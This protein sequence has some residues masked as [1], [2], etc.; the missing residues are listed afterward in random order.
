MNV[1]QGF[2]NQP[3]VSGDEHGS[4][5]NVNF[6]PSKVRLSVQRLS[7]YIHFIS[8]ILTLLQIVGNTE[9]RLFLLGI[10][11]LWYPKERT[12]GP[13][14]VFNITDIEKCFITPSDFLELSIRVVWYPKLLIFSQRRS[15]LSKARE[16]QKQEIM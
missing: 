10:W 6:N 3:A 11:S 13:L 4:A 12:N 8:Q 7:A 14:Q 2:N 5:K 9:L 1:K 15:L 16:E